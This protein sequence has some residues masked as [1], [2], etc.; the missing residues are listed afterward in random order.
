LSRLNGFKD[1]AIEELRNL[2]EDE[3]DAA[4]DALFAY[5]TSDERQ[6]RLTP[7]QVAEVRRIRAALRDGTTRLAAEDEVNAL[8]KKSASMNG[9]FTLEALTHIAGIRFY[10]E[11]RSSRA[12]TRIVERIFTE[13]ARLAEYPQIGHVGT[14]PGTL[15]WTVAGLPYIIVHQIDNENDEVI[16]L[17]VFH[18]AQAR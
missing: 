11:S 10:I 16:V 5:I 2:P 3:Q 8:R 17:G 15:E 13:A 12:A 1:K 7:Y 18:G 9:R 6:Y 4:A 14:V